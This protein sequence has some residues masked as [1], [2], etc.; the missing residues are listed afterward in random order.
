LRTFK[1]STEKHRGGARSSLLSQLAEL[2]LAA[3]RGGCGA[4]VQTKLAL[5]KEELEA[6]TP[7]EEFTKEPANLTVPYEAS[8]LL[9]AAEKWADRLEYFGLGGS[10]GTLL[11]LYTLSDTP[12][13]AAKAWDLD[14]TIRDELERVTRWG[15]FLMGKAELPEGVQAHLQALMEIEAAH[16]GKDAVGANAR[17]VVRRHVEAIYAAFTN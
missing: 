10:I 1:T 13:D 11:F 16:Q 14:T 12:G 3:T 5:V 4:D 7:A 6:P 15:P 17:N 2:N 9:C 8:V